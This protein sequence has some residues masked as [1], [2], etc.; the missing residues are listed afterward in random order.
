MHPRPIKLAAAAFL[1]AVLAG[2][3]ARAGTGSLAGTVVAYPGGEPLAGIRVY[4]FDPRSSYVTA[5]TGDDGGWSMEGLGEG[6]WRVR[7]WPDPEVGQ[8]LIGAW[9]GDTY[10][11]CSTPPVP[12]PGDGGA[13]G[14]DIALPEGGRV[15]GRI[16]ARDDGAPVAGATV[17]FRGVDFY[18]SY[19]V[20][21]AVTSEDGT[22]TV[23]GL[24]SAQDA[25][26]DYLVS[27]TAEG[28]PEWWWP[29]AYTEAEATTF[30]AVRGETLPLDLEMP[31]GGRIEGTVSLPGGEPAAGASVEAVDA[32][33][34]ASG[35]R[36][37]ADASGAFTLGGLP[38]GSWRLR[39]AVA[40]AGRTWWPGVAASAEAGALDVGEDE[41]SGGL[42][43]ELLPE[44]V[45]EVAIGYR[46]EP[47]AG[48]VV[49]AWYGGTELADTAAADA[50]GIAVLDGLAAGPYGLYVNAPSGWAALSGWWA[51]G[52]PTGSPSPPSSVEVQAGVSSRVDAELGAA[53]ALS[54]TVVERETGVGLG[55]LRVYAVGAG[56]GAG[57]WLAVSGEGGAFAFPA[58]PPGEY[59]VHAETD[60][61]CDGDPGWAPA[62]WGGARSEGDAA[63]FTAEAGQSLPS[64][65]VEAPRD[66]DGDDMADVWERAW[67]LD[68][69]SYEDR[70][71]DPDGDGLFN[72]DEY[73]L[74]TAP[75]ANSPAPPPACAASGGGAAGP[76]APVAL[77]LAIAGRRRRLGPVASR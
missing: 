17:R 32:A 69:T 58:L 71:E 72:V 22:F 20:I 27:V 64:L 53:A 47:M 45:L 26:G 18:N 33:T 65:V 62:W 55:S 7:A 19:Q 8:N 43:W 5:D 34:G 39:A 1:G 3:P 13:E 38:P 6:P 23:V 68:P 52:E 77:A 44:A 10:Y 59:A 35:A 61:L 73:V 51:L 28:R 56:E 12:V 49:T 2:A 75:V 14:I 11:L 9:Y 24:D 74:A 36:G 66:E 37:T 42:D 40:G 50:G 25:P 16:A 41:T 60:Y 54:G 29:G 21:E 46:G 67:Q 31:A 4:A 70:D 76:A 15:D 30:G 48:A 63:T 57:S